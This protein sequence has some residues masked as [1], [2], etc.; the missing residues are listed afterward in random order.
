MPR[1]TVVAALALSYPTPTL[2]FP[3]RRFWTLSSNPS[4]RW[5]QPTI[6]PTCAAPM[7]EAFVKTLRRSMRH[8]SCAATPGLTT[9]RPP[10]GLPVPSSSMAR[11]AR[12]SCPILRA[13]GAL[14]VTARLS[15]G[16]VITQ[17]RRTS[18]PA[19]PSPPRR[20]SAAARRCVSD[21]SSTPVVTS[22]RPLAN[23]LFECV[24][25]SARPIDSRWRI[26]CV[27]R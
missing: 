25:Y 16:P 4:A 26:V 6:M 18:T 8:S 3:G 22:S 13:L 1:R 5:Q 15:R 10:C 11:P 23:C 24:P 14:R 12:T 2:S 7:V 9:L 19:C 27:R 21:R 20:T 17:R